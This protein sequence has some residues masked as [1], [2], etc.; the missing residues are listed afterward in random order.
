MIL[1]QGIGAQEKTVIE[2]DDSVST[3][4]DTTV[5]LQGYTSPTKFLEPQSCEPKR[6]RKGFENDRPLRRCKLFFELFLHSN[7][8]KF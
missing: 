7:L 4:H 8:N 3:L 6:K 1:F 2:T 5:D